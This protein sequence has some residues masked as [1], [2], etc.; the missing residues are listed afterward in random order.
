M[1]SLERVQSQLGNKIAVIAISEDH[2]GSKAVEPFIDKLGLKAIKVYLDPKSLLE[3]AFKVQGLPTS[4]L[5]D[6]EGKVLGRVEGAA[7]WDA[8]KL[9]EVL[10]SFMGADE[11]INASL[12]RAPH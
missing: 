3:R 5:I 4:F 10:K 2:G 7:D 9:L 12:R 11:T 8:P 6:R 1:P